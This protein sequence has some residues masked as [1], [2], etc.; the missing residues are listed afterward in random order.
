MVVFLAPNTK[1][2]DFKQARIASGSGFDLEL[3]PTSSLL[4]RIRSLAWDDVGHRQTC[5]YFSREMISMN[6]AFRIAC[7]RCAGLIDCLIIL[8]QGEM[9]CGETRTNSTLRRLESAGNFDDS[10]I[11]PPLPI[12]SYRNA[13]VVTHVAQTAGTLGAV[14]RNASAFAFNRTTTRT[15]TRSRSSFSCES[16]PLLLQLSEG[17]RQLAPPVQRDRSQRQGLFQPASSLPSID[18][19][20]HD[21]IWTTCSESTRRDVG[22]GARRGRAGSPARGG[23]THPASEDRA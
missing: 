22:D 2:V 13:H 8:Q 9:H 16:D 14:P 11:P 6:G 4:L 20:S 15:D 1:H 7:F 19:A 18:A 23:G 21:A 5:P 3:E 10:R 17:I 12:G